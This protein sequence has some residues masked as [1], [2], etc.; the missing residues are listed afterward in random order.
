MKA[1]PSIFRGITYRSRVE[2]RWAVF[3][4]YMGVKAQY[5]PEGFDLDGTPYLPDFYVTE[6]D[7]YIEVKGA[8]PGGSERRKCQLLAEATGKRVLLAVGDPSTS[9]GECFRPGFPHDDAPDANTWIARCRKCPRLVLS[10]VTPDETAWGYDLL[11][12]ECENKLRCG[13]KMPVSSAQ[14]ED[15]I[16]KACAYR[17]E[18]AA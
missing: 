2:A 3:L 4:Y 7:I 12:G 6:W 8:I 18:A 13:D 9:L 11:D 10:W 1:L 16:A 5:E 17:F 15:A 14:L